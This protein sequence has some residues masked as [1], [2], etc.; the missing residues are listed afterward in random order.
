MLSLLSESQSWYGGTFKVVT[1]QFSRLYTIHAEKYSMLILC[2]YALL[3][4]K[5]ELT[6]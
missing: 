2:V 3:T 6:Y 4:K 5:G 1:E